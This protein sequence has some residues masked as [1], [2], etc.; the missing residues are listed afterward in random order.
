VGA[1]GLTCILAAALLKSS[2]ERTPGH[3]LRR[4]RQRIAALF[5][6]LERLGRQADRP[7][8]AADDATSPAASSVTNATPL[9]ESPLAA[10][11]RAW[12]LTL[13]RWRLA[14]ELTPADALRQLRGRLPRPSDPPEAPPPADQVKEL[15]SREARVDRWCR[16]AGELLGQEAQAAGD[17]TPEQ[18]HRQ[19]QAAQQRL[20]EWMAAAAAETAAVADRAKL[21]RKWRALQRQ[22]RAILE[23]YGASRVTELVQRLHQQ[24]QRA[25]ARA[26]Y[27]QLQRSFQASLPADPARPRISHWLDQSAAD[28][29]DERDRQRDAL[30]L[31]QRQLDDAQQELV[32]QLAE[33]SRLA[34]RPQP[35]L[36]H[37]PA[38]DAAAVAHQRRDR[39]AMALA[40]AVL[41]ELARLEQPVS[42]ETLASTSPA[43]QTSLLL[44]WATD[45]FRQLSADEAVAIGW[46]DAAM[47]PH[48]LAGDGSVTS[49]DDLDADRLAALVIALQLSLVRCLGQR[50]GH[51]P[52]VLTDR[53]FDAGAR[54]LA[55]FA[56][57]LC[58]Q[59]ASGQQVL[60]VTTQT[61]VSE[62]FRRFDVPT[63]IVTRQAPATG[64]STSPAEAAGVR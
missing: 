6:E 60:V 64:A 62:Q 38:T 19:L 33:M 32:R 28:L 13:Q 25:L 44:Q 24:Q 29:E 15:R 49:V 20:A 46:D 41:A 8:D 52:L 17:Q 40:G 36:V 7:T 61:V 56:R 23:A 53:S 34:G 54:Q 55:P 50:I 59:A 45:N 63:L 21:R 51:L 43:R 27:E 14:P 35:P 47:G 16:R 4:Q 30:R 9:A 1:I 37:S 18:W 2:F 42:H 3:H 22:G 31:V 26:E 11:E 5:A 10:A 12:Q 57:L 48:I 58:D 39:Q